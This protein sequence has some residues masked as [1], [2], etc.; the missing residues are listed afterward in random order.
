MAD[1]TGKFLRVELGP[2]EIGKIELRIGALKEEKITET[3]LPGGSDD[4]VGIRQVPGVEVSP[5][6]LIG[7][8]ARI[9]DPLMKE[10]LYGVNHFLAG[11]V[12]QG[13]SKGVI[14]K[15]SR[16]SDYF[17]EGF[18]N[19]PGEGIDSSDDLKPNFI[20]DQF[21]RAL[22]EELPEEA[23]EKVYFFRGAVPIFR[24]EG[25]KRQKVNVVGFGCLE[26]WGNVINAGSMA[27]PP[28]QTL[29]LSPAAIAVHDNGNM[30][31]IRDLKFF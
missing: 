25:V 30:L 8:G 22:A 21:L 18:A 5:Q 20:V 17:V 16:L 6:V 3:E 15:M 19:F 13:E 1:G 14:W 26:D 7:K 29:A 31:R 23:H 10:G 11:T 4:E 28:R 24:A 9:L 2:A 12:I 27:L